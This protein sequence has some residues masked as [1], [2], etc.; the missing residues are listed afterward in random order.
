M[1]N[2]TPISGIHLEKILQGDES[3]SLLVEED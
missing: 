3:T 1:S 2:P